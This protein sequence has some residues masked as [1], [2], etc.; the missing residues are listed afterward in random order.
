M[1]KIIA[2]IIVFSV[3]VIGCKDKPTEPYQA[4]KQKKV[5]KIG[6]QV[7]VHYTGTFPDG[8]V[9]DQSKGRGP[10]KFKVGSGQMIQK[11]DEAVVGMKLKEEKKITIK[12]E[13]AYGATYKAY[14][15]A[16]F[17]AGTKF[18]KGEVNSV[19]DK[20]GKAFT[21]FIHDVKGDQVFLKNNHPLAGK[22]LIFHIKVLYIH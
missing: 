21:V 15:K 16:V 4:V 12:P 9:F 11:F 18:K 10:L 17:A 20:S 8:K 22:T 1:K 6:D 13:D 5:V 3:L 14:P 19:K 7:S 2:L